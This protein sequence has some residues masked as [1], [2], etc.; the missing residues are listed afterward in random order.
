MKDLVKHSSICIVLD[1]A[2]T[3]RALYYKSRL[4]ETRFRHIS[5]T[6]RSILY[7]Y[8]HVDI[9]VTVLAGD[10]GELPIIN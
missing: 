2:Q 6:H 8:N 1:T 7:S 3:V 4:S 5:M 10:A 9:N